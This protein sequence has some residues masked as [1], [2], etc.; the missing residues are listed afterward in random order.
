M[1][2]LI[3]SSVW[4]AGASPRNRECLLLRRLL[5]GDE[6]LYYLAPIQVEVCQG[7]RSE[8]EFHR[9]WEGFLGLTRLEIED[10]H[11]GLSAWNY[12]KARQKGITVAT[13]DCLIGTVAKECRVPLW[14]LDRDFRRLQPI[15][16]FEIY[17]P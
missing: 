5:Q 15:I 4:I 13:I 6:L 1:A 3:D 12:L 14:S 16:G 17:R 11:W 9:L 7:A 2:V 8:A 10:R